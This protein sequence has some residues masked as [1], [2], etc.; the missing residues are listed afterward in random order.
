MSDVGLNW[1]NDEGVGDI[2]V[3][4]GDLVGDDTIRTGILLSL[5]CDARA[6]PDDELPDPN[7]DPRGFWGDSY[8]EVEGDVWGSRLWLFKTRENTEQTRGQF[9]EAALEALQWMIDDRVASSIDFVVLT[10][11]PGDYAAGRFPYRVTVNPPAGD[12]H[13]FDFVWGQS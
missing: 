3:A 6:R 4:A 1:D 10:P 11:A 8:P 9:K 2:A 12:P 5:H 7:G 13:L